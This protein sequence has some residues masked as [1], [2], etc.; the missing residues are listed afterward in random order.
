MPLFGSVL[1]SIP[2]P[3]KGAPIM[4]P[5]D[6]LLTTQY[7]PVASALLKAD[8]WRVTA[9]FTYLI[10]ETKR[11]TVPAGYLTDGASV[12]RVFWNVIPP[13]GKYGQA[14]VV[15]DLL[16]EYLSIIDDGVPVAISRAY[17]DSVLNDAMAALGVPSYKRLAIYWSVCAYRVLANVTEPSNTPLK[18]R[19][20]AEW[21]GE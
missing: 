19:L 8:H 14:A 3:Q 17:C 20:E 7:D 4:T 5:F 1:S 10:S 12:P 13:W 15:H 6:R 21:R 18:R 2:R 16:C 9:P 11:V